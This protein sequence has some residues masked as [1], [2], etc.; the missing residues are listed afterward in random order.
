MRVEVVEARDTVGMRV[1]VVEARGLLA[2][3]AVPNPFV[4]LNVVDAEFK[5]VSKAVKTKA[6]PK[7]AA[8]KWNA[9]F[10]LDNDVQNAA[11]LAFEVYSSSTWSKAKPL[12]RA[13]VAM[14]EIEEDATWLDL[15]PWGDATAV[16]GEIRVKIGGADEVPKWFEDDQLGDDEGNCLLVAVIKGKLK[17]KAYVVL[18]VVDTNGAPVDSGFEVRNKTKAQKADFNETF[19]IPYS[20]KQYLRAQVFDGVTT[21]LIGQALVTSLPPLDDGAA[22]PVWYGLRHPK[23]KSDDPRESGELELAVKLGHDPAFDPSEATRNFFDDDDDENDEE[24]NELRVAICRCRGLRAADTAGFRKAPSSDPYCKVFLNNAPWLFQKTTTKTRTLDPVFN[25][26][27]AFDIDGSAIR[28]AQKDAPTSLDIEVFDY[29]IV[30]KDDL[31][32]SLSIDLR[33]VVLE[34]HV[35]EKWYPLQLNNDAPRLGDIL[36]TVQSR[37]TKDRI[38]DPFSQDKDLSA[39]PN[40]LRVALFKARGLA[41][42]AGW[43]NCLASAVEVDF[44]VRERENDILHWTSGSQ[45]WTRDNTADIVWREL[46]DGLPL[47]AGREYDLRIDCAAVNAQ[48]GRKKS[49]GVTSIHLGAAEEAK[50]LSGW[51]RL[52]PVNETNAKKDLKGTPSSSYAG[53]LYLSVNWQYNRGLDYVPPFVTDGDDLSCPV[54]ELCIGLVQGK[55]IHLPRPQVKFE[56][57]VT[58]ERRILFNGVATTKSGDTRLVQTQTSSVGGKSSANPVWRESYSM[59]LAES[60]ASLRVQCFDHDSG[61]LGEA[62]V[63]LAPML[64]RKAHRAWYTL[65]NKTT[66]Q[67]EVIL[68]WRYNVDYDLSAT[69]SF[70]NDDEAEAVET[71][72]AP[73]P[74]PPT[75][76]EEEALDDPK[77]DELIAA[78]QKV[79]GRDKKFEGPIR[80]RAC[81]TK[82][83]DMV[84][85]PAALREYIRSQSSAGI[86]ERGSR[87]GRSLLHE[88]VGSGSEAAVKM[89]LEDF[90]ANVNVRSLL[91]RDTPLHVAAKRSRRR[92]AFLLLE[93]Y[94]ATADD[95][96]AMGARPLHY[97]T[98]LSIVRLLLRHGAR[99]DAHDKHGKSPLD[100]ARENRASSNVID[101]LTSALIQQDRAR[102]LNS[103]N[104]EREKKRAMDEAI[105]RSLEAKAREGRLRE[106]DML[107]LDYVAWRRGDITGNQLEE[108]RRKKQD[109]ILLQQRLEARFLELANAERK[110]Q[111]Q[112]NIKSDDDNDTSDDDD[113]KKDPL[114]TDVTRGK[115][116]VATAAFG[117]ASATGARPTSLTENLHFHR[118]DVAWRRRYSASAVPAEQQLETAG[119]RRVSFNS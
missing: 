22:V 84:V 56:A 20:P 9:S 42:M 54:N 67:I 91:G 60:L 66:E 4:S 88:A 13:L 100:W 7:T 69:R 71:E 74:E 115:A 11:F 77:F 37:F 111:E 116:A 110:L 1:E 87:Y 90:G 119:R 55:N 21:S 40:E 103:I 26:A 14:D 81:D 68:R 15:V 94:G 58:E 63:D 10:V 98:E 85:S 39:P 48:F 19:R 27:F 96:N 107:R 83:Y 57:F 79:L 108:A 51:Y 16:T 30:G 46:K 62:N 45:K 61:V 35:T 102:Y 86:D 33:D 82:L 104:K 38:F 36:V 113:V 6:V 44:S 34:Q 59:V 2:L 89:L 117:S 32:G 53:E 76:E 28:H 92:I 23:S 101:E 109:A 105:R 5:P 95:P 64:H 24:P 50:V 25:E 8:P 99:V 114:Q 18:D 106:K 73:A 12:G 41:S 78:T 31:L 97:A 3:E 93:N 43:N 72:E 80:L 118:D 17:K 65:E 75:E 70:P 29:V 52:D 112:Q 47:E 49:I